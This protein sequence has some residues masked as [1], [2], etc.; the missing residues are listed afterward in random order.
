[1]NSAA[2]SPEA[3]AVI[4][5]LRHIGRIKAKFVSERVRSELQ[6]HHLVRLDRVWLQITDRGMSVPAVSRAA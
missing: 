3:Y 4:R 2:L 5:G 6:D 1:M